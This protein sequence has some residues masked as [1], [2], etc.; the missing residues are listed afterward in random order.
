MDFAAEKRRLRAL[1]DGATASEVGAGLTDELTNEDLMARVAKGDQV[2]FGHLHDRLAPMVYGLARR[3]VRDPQLAEEISQ[4]ALLQ[5]W[6]SAP[7][8]GRS[9]GTVHT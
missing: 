3:V 8:Y 7:R 6:K 4:E 9:N 1:P 5:I 2:A